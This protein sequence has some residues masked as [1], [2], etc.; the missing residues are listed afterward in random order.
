MTGAST[1]IGRAVVEHLAARDVP[2]FAGVRRLPDAPERANV[3]PLRLDVTSADDIA[4]AVAAVGASSGLRGL[5]NNAGIGKGGAV[6]TLDL[7][8]LREQLEVNVVG[9]VAV[10]QA[11]LPLLRRAGGGR[12]VFTGSISSKVGMPFMGPYVASKHAIL[13]LAESLRREV[14]GWDIQ[15]VT[16][17]PGNIDTPI[18]AKASTESGRTRAQMSA[19]HLA[20]YGA[21]HEK[22]GKAL[23]AAAGASIPPE[24][25]ARA[26]YKALFARRPRAEYLVGADAHI[27][28]TLSALLPHRVVDALVARQL[29]AAK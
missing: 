22:F 27:L 24:R 15:V 4:A 11:F 16:V 6:E 7:A 26:T 28:T 3:T 10:T 8:D 21:E 25:V 20:L 19:E 5:V 1:G 18:W 17:L 29:D 23:A 12:V 9:Q 13:G 14:A 2:V